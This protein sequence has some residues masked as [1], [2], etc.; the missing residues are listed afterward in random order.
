MFAYSSALW[1]SP[2]RRVRTGVRRVG[3][4][5]ACIGWNVC[6]ATTS[7]TSGA[8]PRSGAVVRGTPQLY[9]GEKGAC[10][11]KSDFIGH[12]G[13]CDVRHIFSG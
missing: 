8:T 12:L 5:D 9:T 1:Q 3:V 4:A 7:R 2:N 10:Q 6:H 11:Y 13:G